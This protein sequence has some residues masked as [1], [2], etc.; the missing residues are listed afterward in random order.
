MKKLGWQV[1]GVD[2]DPKAVQVA[3]SNGL[4]VYAGSLEEQGLPSNTYDAIVMAH[5]IEHVHNPVQLLTECYRILKPVGK[6]IVITPNADGMGHA[7]FGRKWRGLE[8]PRHLHIFNPASLSAL[9]KLSGFAGLTCR[10]HGMGRYIIAASLSQALY[11]PKIVTAAR[12]RIIMVLAE[13]MG[14]AG[15]LLH[16]MTKKSSDEIALIAVKPLN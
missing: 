1:E 3:R 9:V 13:F 2:F 14:L 10:S 5:V 12:N 16:K 7:V 8:P 6:L 4:D 15:L 11:F